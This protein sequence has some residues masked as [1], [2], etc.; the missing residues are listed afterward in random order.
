MRENKKLGP[1][2]QKIFVGISYLS[3]ICTILM[4]IDYYIV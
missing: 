3:A 4:F 1:I 2:M